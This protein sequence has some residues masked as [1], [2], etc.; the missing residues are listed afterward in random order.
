MQL[1]IA[2]A[3]E[4]FFSLMVLT[5]QMSELPMKPQDFQEKDADRVERTEDMIC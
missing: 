1:P 3:I 5:L 2:I 4:Q